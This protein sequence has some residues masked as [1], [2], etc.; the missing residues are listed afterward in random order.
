L[1]RTTRGAYGDLGRHV[2]L[3]LVKGSCS[4][5]LQYQLALTPKKP[6]LPKT[7]LPPPP[8]T[9]MTM[10]RR[11]TDPFRSGVKSSTFRQRFAAR[12][13]P[14]AAMELAGRRHLWWVWAALGGT[15]CLGL[16]ALIN[17][18]AVDS[19]ALLFSKA[20]EAARTGDW[21]TSQQY[22]RA[23]NGTS[24]AKG[25]SYLGEARACLALGQAHEAELNLHQAIRTEPPEP[26]SWRLLLEILRVE[27]R[28]VDVHRLGWQAYDKVYPSARRDLLRQLT[29]AF[30]A[31]LLPEEKIRTTLR[32][33]VEADIN[34]V[35]AQIALWQRI[36]AQPRAGD[37]DRPSI[38]AN[39][40]SLLAKQPEHTGVREALATSLADA[41]EPD[42]GR[43]VLDA[44]PEL[45]RDARYWR[46]R[47][48]WE[49]EYEHRPEQAANA[50]QTALKELPHDWRTWYR[51]SRA[52]RILDRQDESRQAA[53]TVRRIREVIDPLILGPRLHAAFDHL[54]DPKAL[55]DLAALC[56]QAGLTH[57]S[58]AWLTEAQHVN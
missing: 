43:A 28:T 52:L 49:L 17:W 3:P 41:G 13:S 47:G 23:I 34:D 5:G 58:N 36:M 38:L 15:A 16:L 39:L 21:T 29:L 40:E 4:P 54:N 27:D 46:L 26:E 6:F 18:M 8:V 35:D 25:A 20:E 12:Q 32:R 22:W 19:S 2:V 24:A 11:P 33:W 7:G 51:L 30:L 31:D 57:L 1:A 55:A 48:R 50:F 37:P 45:T 9:A 56:D 10:P 53:E 14:Q 42:R 44:W